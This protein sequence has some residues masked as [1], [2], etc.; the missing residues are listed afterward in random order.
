MV[1]YETWIFPNMVC[2]SEA[3]VDL[4]VRDSKGELNKE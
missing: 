3:T 4:G 1:K 2:K